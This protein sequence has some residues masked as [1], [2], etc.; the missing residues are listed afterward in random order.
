MPDN[1]DNVKIVNVDRGL[2]LLRYVSADDVEDAP[3]VS[4][5]A[6]TRDVIE[7]L[8]DPTETL[9]AL[10]QPGGSLVINAHAN[11]RL[12]IAISPARRS[13]S[14]KAVINIEPIRSGGASGAAVPSAARP[15]PIPERLDLSSFRVLG[16]VSRVGDVYVGPDQWLAGP[17]APSRI[18][19]LAIEWPGKP[20]DLDLRY[21]VVLAKTV[22]P[23]NRPGYLGEFVGTRG[24]SMPILGLSLEL[25]GGQFHQCQ[26]VAEALYLG[27][28]LM[29][30]TGAQIDLKGPTGREPLVGLR[31][32]VQ[33]NAGASPRLPAPQPA[34]APIANAPAAPSRALDQERNPGQVRVFRRRT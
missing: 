30:V 5:S 18:E 7:I 20:A 28:P 25:V 3:L 33:V 13:R 21:S 1:S 17:D 2:Y 27:A 11:G 26:L 32:G 23:A 14:V 16:H 24:K 19:G 31:I 9:P 12:R 29:R 15:A 6:E 22:G 34:A 4:I 10:W 8:H